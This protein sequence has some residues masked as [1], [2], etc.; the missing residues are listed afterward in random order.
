MC[1][2]WRSIQGW[3]DYYEVS[4]KGRVRRIAPGKNTY[5]G[6]VLRPGRVSKTGHLHVVLCTGKRLEQRTLHRLVATAFLPL[7]E[8]DTQRSFVAHRDNDASNNEVGNLYWAT[9]S[10]NNFDQVRHGTA[11]GRV[12]E[13]RAPVTAET[14]RFLRQ[15]S[16]PAAQLAAVVGLSAATITQIRRRETHKYV[17]AEIGDYIIERPRRMFTPEQVRAIRRDSR[18]NGSISRHHGVSPNTIRAIKTG[19]SYGYVSDEP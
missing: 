4:S 9:P 14:V 11:K 3:E 18:S 10:E 7:P 15:D 17:P 1:E 8:K 19:K 2:I 6:K 5:V 12:S 13:L 16:R